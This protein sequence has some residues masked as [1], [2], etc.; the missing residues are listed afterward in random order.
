MGHIELSRAADLVVVAPASADILAKMAAGLAM[1]WPPHCCWPPTS[2]AG[3]AGDEC[4]DVA[5]CGDA[6]EHGD[7]GGA[8]RAVVGRM[9]GRWPATNSA[10]PPGRAA[11]DPAPRS[12]A[13]L[14]PAAGRWPGGMPGHQRPTHEP[15]DPVRYIANRSSGKQGHA[16][17]AALAA[18]GARVTLVS[19]PVWDSPPRRRT[20]KLM[21]PPSANASIATGLSRI[22]WAAPGIMGGAE[23]EVVV[24]TAQG[25][26]PWPKMG[27]AEL[28]AKLAEQI[29]S[30]L[31]ER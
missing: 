22:M 25:A 9:R 12:Q 28:A 15:I 10:R 29:G 27:K 1:I 26:T 2:R 20:W 13:L 30:F 4:A 8:R 19:G 23:N 7:P 18:L 14:A 11:G 16:I 24:I 6:G 3:G 31:N 5:A 21:P 17:A